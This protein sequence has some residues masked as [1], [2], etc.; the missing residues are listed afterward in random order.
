MLVPTVSS[1]LGTSGK[2]LFGLLVIVV[3]IP[4]EAYTRVFE[5]KFNRPPFKVYCTNLIN[6][7]EENPGALRN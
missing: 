4:S 7:E 5:S 6:Y 3:T 2:A 1:Y